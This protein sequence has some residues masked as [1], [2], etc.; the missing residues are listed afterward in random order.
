MKVEGYR[1]A[2]PADYPLIVSM[3]QQG[4]DRVLIRSI[5]QPTREPYP[6]L[7]VSRPPFCSTEEGMRGQAIEGGERIIRICPENHWV[8]MRQDD[9]NW[10]CIFGIDAY[11][12][13]VPG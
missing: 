12:L 2:T 4:S 8:E 11:Q 7:N 1:V 5:N 9:G 6:L 3:L 10:I 13:L